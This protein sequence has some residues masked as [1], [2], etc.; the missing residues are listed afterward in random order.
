MVLNNKECTIPEAT[1]QIIRNTAKELGYRPNKL[2]VGLLKKKTGVLGLIIPDNSNM[3]FSELSKSVEISARNLGYNIIYGNTN[4]VYARDYEYLKL[5]VD[6]QV[7]GIVITKSSNLPEEEEDIKNLSFL[8]KYAIPYVVVDRQPENFESNLVTVDNTLGGYMATKYLL[9]NGHRKIAT[10]TG[11]LQLSTGRRRLEGYKKA[12][13]EYGIE[14]DDQLVFEGNFTMG[15][16]KEALK[17]FLQNKA[18]AVF[19][20]ND[21]MAFG[22]YKE[23]VKNNIRIPD[24]LSVIGYDNISLT[25]IVYPGLTTIN[26]PIKEIGEE[27]V[28]ILIEA[29]N[30]ENHAPEVKELYPSLVVRESVKKIKGE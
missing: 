9:D 6:H 4:D 23:A 20:Q 19:C 1:K 5:F 24:D 13:A 7:D 16:E 18:T 17:Q 8:K 11:P 29:I 30:N 3:F 15:R 25:D 27:S 14:F 2:A 22:I 12:I 10:Y 26:Q 21:I 28:R